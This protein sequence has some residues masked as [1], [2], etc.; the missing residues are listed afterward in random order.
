M[1]NILLLLTFMISMV[2][3]AGDNIIVSHGAGKSYVKDNA[4]NLYPME[5][6]FT[7]DGAGNIVPVTSTI[8]GIT[9]GTV[10][11][12]TNGSSASAWFTQDLVFKADFDSWKTFADANLSTLATD[13]HLVS[14]IAKFT[15]TANGL[16]VDGS[17]VTQPISGS[18][19]VSNFPSTQPVSGTIT[20]NIGT[21]GSLALDSSVQAINT[22]LTT[23]VNGLKVDGSAVTQPVSASALPLPTNASQETG[24]NLASIA[25]SASSINTKIT[26]SSN[27]IKVDGSLVTQP[28]SA[29]SLPL[30]TNA[31]IESGGNL[32]SINSKI[33]TTVNGLKVDGSG[34]TQPVSG[35]VG[36][37][38]SGNWSARLQDG[39]G[40]IVTSQLSSA[41]RALDVGINV[42]GVQVDPR[43][44]TWNLSNSTDSVASVESGTWNITNVS[45]TVSLPTGAATSALQTTGNTSLATIATNTPALGAAVTASSSPV[46]I[47][48]DQIVNVAL[49][50][51]GQVNVGVNGNLTTTATTANQVVVT[52]T[53]TSGKTFYLSSWDISVQAT[54]VSATATTWG[55]CA[56]QSPGGTTLWQKQFGGSGSVGYDKEPATPLNFPAGQV[57]EI[58]CT[59]AAGTSFSWYGNLVGYEK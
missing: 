23:T 37:T 53:V 31:A 4:G 10:N 16:K 29:T 58:V 51:T 8:S 18:V 15:D 48:S 45:G 38:Q 54:T 55:T 6:V 9:I 41:Q 50:N 49:G 13:A 22:K 39:N 56:L 52:H 11:Q 26:T 5:I 27:G 7:G 43:N 44:R 25:T 59:P 1:K 3:Y 32:A 46:N 24:G 12:G 14:L 40:N 36:A 19:S 30:P 47:A 57:V 20:A 34:V 33:T 42:S 2:A 28:V 35:T 17:A 21:V